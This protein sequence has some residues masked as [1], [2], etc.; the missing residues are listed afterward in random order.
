[1]PRKFYKETIRDF[2]IEKRGTMRE[3][4]YVVTYGPE[5]EFRNSFATKLKALAYVKARVPPSPKPRPINEYTRVY[6]EASKENK[7]RDEEAEQKKRVA[8]GLPAEPIYGMAG[9]H[10]QRYLREMKSKHGDNWRPSTN[11]VYVKKEPPP[12]S[13]G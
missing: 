1:M 10:A 8:L 13:D 5:R 2:T 9:V 11:E 3:P 7:R 12:E 4:R 6:N